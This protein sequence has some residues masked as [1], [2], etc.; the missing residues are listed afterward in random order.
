MSLAFEETDSEMLQIAGICQDAEVDADLNPGKA[1]FRRSQLLDAVRCQ[2]GL[3]PILMTLSEKNQLLVGNAYMRQMA[4]KM[5]PANPSLGVRKVIQLM[6]AGDAGVN[7]GQILGIDIDSLLPG[8]T[9][10]LTVAVTV[11]KLRKS[12]TTNIHPDAVLSS[13]L[14]KGPTFVLAKHAQLTRSE[15]DALRKGDIS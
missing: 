14:A 12:T 5:D 1:V 8:T 11:I 9:R 4:R 6:E 7:L 13:L 2:A 10:S 15:R 3:K